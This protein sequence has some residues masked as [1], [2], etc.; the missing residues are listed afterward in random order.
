MIKIRLARGG[1]KG[2]PHYRIVVIEER[3]KREGKFLDVIGFWYPKKN[4]KKINKK[5]LEKWL[6]VGAQKTKS[7]NKLIS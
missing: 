2:N 6:A 1:S 4:N 7:V 5:K 3:R